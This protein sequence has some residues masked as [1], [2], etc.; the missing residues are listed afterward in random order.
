MFTISNRI[1]MSK[2]FFSIMWLLCTPDSEK[3]VILITFL[4]TYS[5]VAFYVNKIK[6]RVCIGIMSNEE[7]FKCMSETH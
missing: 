5:V 1:L 3:I 7:T 6:A 4:M 2:S